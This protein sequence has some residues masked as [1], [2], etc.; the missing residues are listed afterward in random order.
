MSQIVLASST[1]VADASRWRDLPEDELRRRAVTAC[2]DR[3]VAALCSLMQSQLVMHGK[4]GAH[5]SPLTLAAYTLS[6]RTL[7][8]DWHDQS[9]T[10]P[11]RDAGFRWCRQLEERGLKPSTVTQ[12]LAGARM[13]YAALRWSGATAADPFKDVK[14]ARDKVAPW[15]KRAP[16]A[17]ADVDRLLA[18]ANTP[19]DAAL[20]LLAAHAGLRVSEIMALRFD[21]LDLSA[22]TLTVRHGKGGKARKAPISQTLSRVLESLSRDNEYVIASYRSTETARRHIARLC[23]RAGV[24]YKSAHALRHTA[25]TRLMRERRDLDAVARFLGHSQVETSRVYSK[26]SDEALKDSV[27]NW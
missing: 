6:V 25:G 12:R 19:E 2:R 3:D 11:S 18:A 13:L 22:R 24:S 23:Q 9:L 15:D 8:K 1:L 27:G 17:D 5:V 21:D 16:Y 14:P 7:V 20:I 4:S 26:W 10:N